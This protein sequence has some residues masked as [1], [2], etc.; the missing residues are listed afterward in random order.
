MELLTNDIATYSQKFYIVQRAFCVCASNDAKQ[1]TNKNGRKENYNKFTRS[2]RMVSVYLSNQK[3]TGKRSNYIF[4]YVS[5]IV[6]PVEK[7]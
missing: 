1:D 4:R 6:A 7:G 2:P 3:D 5:I